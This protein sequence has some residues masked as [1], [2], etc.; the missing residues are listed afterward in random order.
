MPATKELQLTFQAGSPNRLTGFVD[1]D[2][3]G[4]EDTRLFG[5][6][7]TVAGGA[8]VASSKK[9]WPSPALRVSML[10]HHNV[11]PRGHG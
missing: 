8:V 2:W 4:D 9:Q 1:A 5:F 3:A 7:F 10:L 11:P 6:F